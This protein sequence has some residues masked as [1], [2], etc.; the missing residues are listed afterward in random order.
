MD[1]VNPARPLVLGS[2]PPI[3]TPSPAIFDQGHNGLAG[4]TNRN[5]NPNLVSPPSSVID[6]HE[7]ESQNQR[8]KLELLER[9]KQHHLR[10]FLHY[11]QLAEQE[12]KQR[13]KQQQQQQLFLSQS[14]GLQ[15]EVDPAYQHHDQQQQQQGLGKTSAWIASLAQAEQ[16]RQQS[17]VQAVDPSSAYIYHSPGSQIDLSGSN[18]DEVVED[19]IA[20][21][22]AYGEE[23]DSPVH[24]TN[25]TTTPPTAAGFADS[26]LVD[27]SIVE[28]LQSN[29][30]SRSSISSSSGT[31]I[32]TPS[33]PASVSA[34]HAGLDATN[35][36]IK[37]VVD[38]D[39]DATAFGVN[40]NLDLEP[41]FELSPY[42]SFNQGSTLVEN[43][44]NVFRST[45]DLK[46]DWTDITSYASM[47]E[48]QDRAGLQH[49]QHHQQQQQANGM[50]VQKRQMMGQDQMYQPQNQQ[51]QQS[52]HM[53]AYAARPMDSMGAGMQ[54]QYGGNGYEPTYRSNVNAMG[55]GHQM[56]VGA[57]FDQGQGQAFPAPHQQQ[58][59]Q[60][61]GRMAMMDASSRYGMYAGDGQYSNIVSNGNSNQQVPATMSS[62]GSGLG[63][64]NIYPG[65]SGMNPNQ[66]QPQSVSGRTA[67]SGS[68]HYDSGPY[69]S[70]QPTFNGRVLPAYASIGAVVQASPT[71][72]HMQPQQPLQQQ[73][74]QQRQEQGRSSIGLN[75]PESR[76]NQ[77]PLSDYH[78]NMATQNADNINHLLMSGGAMTGSGDESTVKKERVSPKLNNESSTDELEQIA[79]D[80]LDDDDD[81]RSVGSLV[82]ELDAEVE[83]A[84]GGA[85]S[86]RRPSQLRKPSTAAAKAKSHRKTPYDRKADRVETGKRRTKSIS[87]TASSSSR[88]S[89]A[90]GSTN[91]SEI[92]LS[93]RAV[94]SRNILYEDGKPKIRNPLGGGRGYVPGETPDDPSKK[95]KCEVCGRGFARL[96]NLKVSP[97]PV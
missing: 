71:H 38:S 54:V 50:L 68:F 44:V 66:M 15:Y 85:S 81:E 74:S 83:A 95:H 12:E 67:G 4:T 29:S 23:S 56:M 21:L 48:D 86:S 51:Q 26:Q 42:G 5:I 34:G 19:T 25:G 78:R 13:E 37:K 9:Q 52:Q 39:W 77:S 63:G 31:V 18:S 64:M 6:E 92:V 14:I 3:T 82:D 87:A 17:Q 89:G 32:H 76:L 93:D 73:P 84:L 11:R 58:Q 91:G 97:R 65:M 46:K 16:Q 45:A 60:Q 40:L 59:Q 72:A 61:Q 24:T 94:I 41:A 62:N 43:N 36:S 80:D 22:I 70:F 10:Q 96:F 30:T 49:V 53:A 69:D 75:S 47:Y 57:Q 2:S 55:P 88:G 90:E 20:D 7:R 1:V 33:P 28:L 35:N 8:R 79:E 27:A